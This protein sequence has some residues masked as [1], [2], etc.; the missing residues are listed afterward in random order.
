MFIKT[1]FI[2][3]GVIIGFM[4][5]AQGQAQAA[6]PSDFVAQFQTQARTTTPAFTPSAERGRTFFNQTHGKEWSC[7]SC[8]TNDP[9][10]NGKHASTQRVIEAMATRINTDRFTNADKVEKWFRRNCNDV[11]GRICTPAEK[12]DVI[13]YL[14]SL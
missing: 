2:F 11:L 9:K 10:Q 5:Q 8:H 7:S 12:A 4:S 6:Q 3:F 1:I 13:T 14:M